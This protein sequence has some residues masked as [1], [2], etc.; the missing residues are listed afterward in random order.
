MQSG[1]FEPCHQQG[2]SPCPNPAGK[3]RLNKCGW[4]D[5]EERSGAPMRSRTSNLLIRSQPL[6][7]IELWMHP[8]AAKVDLAIQWRKFIFALLPAI[9]PGPGR[10][11][12]RA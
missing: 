2:P 12:S 3:S 6:Y 7:P 10:A 11:A 4:V 8:R 5:R 1:S 9:F